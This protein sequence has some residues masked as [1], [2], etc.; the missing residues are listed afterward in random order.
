MKRGRRVYK[1]EMGMR[2]GIGR[3]T[4]LDWFELKEFAGFGSGEG[5][6]EEGRGEAGGN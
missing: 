6:E 5:R 3:E 4:G 2:I 1:D